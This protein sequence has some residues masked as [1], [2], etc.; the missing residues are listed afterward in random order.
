MAFKARLVE[1]LVTLPS[2]IE[3]LALRVGLLSSSNKDYNVLVS[4][5][6]SFGHEILSPTNKCAVLFSFTN[7]PLTSHPDS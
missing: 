2:S 1:L 5:E 7:Q 6:L 4:G 3:S